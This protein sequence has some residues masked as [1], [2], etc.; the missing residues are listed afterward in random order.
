MQA[1]TKFMQLLATGKPIALRSTTP[2]AEVSFRVGSQRFI[3]GTEQPL[4]ITQQVPRRTLH[5][6]TDLHNLLRMGMLQVG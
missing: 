5:A 4:L 2:G 1:Y 6:A 3:I